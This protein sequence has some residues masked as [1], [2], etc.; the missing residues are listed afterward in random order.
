MNRRDALKR[1]AAGGAIAAGGSFVL[2]SNGVAFAASIGD[3]GLI[4]A[5]A[6]GSP[7]AISVGQAGP[8]G[9]GQV[10]VIGN[11]Q[12]VSCSSGSLMARYGWRINS[13]N[14]APPP[15]SSLVLSDSNG[16]PITSSISGN[17]TALNSNHG[18]VRITRSNGT[19]L[20][21]DSYDI[22]QMVE[23][24]C[25]GSTAY[26]RATYRLIGTG[27]NPPSVQQES[28]QIIG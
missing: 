28:W 25:S 1:L 24:Q 18:T 6:P 13:F 10:V 26:L 2:S 4:G 3:T 21:R 23:W 9:S 22:S 7:V 8:G 5:P 20:K 27:T 14:L 19:P 12:Q 15:G 16:T 17:F 11:A